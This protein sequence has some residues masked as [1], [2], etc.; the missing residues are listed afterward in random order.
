MWVRK[1]SIDDDKKTER[2]PKPI[3]IPF[4]FSLLRK[5]EKKWTVRANVLKLWK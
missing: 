1:Q 2:R 5:S 4:L 3:E